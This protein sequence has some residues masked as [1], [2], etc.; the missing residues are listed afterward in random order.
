MSFIATIRV[1]VKTLQSTLVYVRLEMLRS[2][3]RRPIAIHED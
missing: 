3:E 1:S 2:Y